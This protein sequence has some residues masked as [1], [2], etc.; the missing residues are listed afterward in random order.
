MPSRTALPKTLDASNL[1]SL[2]RCNAWFVPPP[3][4]YPS[5]Y[6]CIGQ[7]RAHVWIRKFSNPNDIYFLME[8]YLP[9]R[10]SPVA[11]CM[12]PSVSEEG[13]WPPFMFVR[14]VVKL[15]HVRRACPGRVYSDNVLWAAV[16]QILA[17]STISRPTNSTSGQGNSDTS[18]VEW[19]TF[20][21]CS[22]Q[23]LTPCAD[24]EK[25]SPT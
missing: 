18:P 4:D 17:T 16:I 5:S 6:L 12:E 1:G 9:I 20:N 7:S 25:N 22:S 13:S 23:T 19:V 8:S 15:N 2:V 11:S 3:I 24:P 14:C 10:V 21:L